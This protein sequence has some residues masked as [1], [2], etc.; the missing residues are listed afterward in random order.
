MN[1]YIVHGREYFKIKDSQGYG[2]CETQ[3]QTIER[4]KKN[5]LV[6]NACLKNYQ[7]RQVIATSAKRA[8]EEV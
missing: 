5:I 4:E 1:D 7:F 3:F 8:K 6:E 2:Q